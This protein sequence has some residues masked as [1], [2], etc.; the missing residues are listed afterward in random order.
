MSKAT[1]RN[2]CRAAE[3]ALEALDN[4]ILACEPPADPSALESAVT[5]AV[6]AASGLAAAICDSH[7]DRGTV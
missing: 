2:L 1:T 6:R 4:L 3:R 7:I 5:A